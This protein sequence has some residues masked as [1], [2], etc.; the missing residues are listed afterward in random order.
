MAKTKVST[1]KFYIVDLVRYKPTTKYITIDPTRV[2]IQIDITTKGILSASEVPSAAFARLEKAARE[3][4]DTYEKVIGSEVERLEKKI[5][6]MVDSGDPQ[7]IAKAEKLA[8]G[9]NVSV[10]NALA[11]AEGAAMKA[12]DE[13]LKKEIQLDKNLKEAQLKLGFKIVVGAVRVTTNIATLVSTMGADVHA[14]YVIAKTCYEVGKEIYE[15]NKGEEKLRKELDAAIKTFIDLRGTTIMQAA[16]R[17]MVD[18]SGLSV[19]KPVEAIK[20]IMGR[21]QAG[22]AE[23]LKGR[24]AKGVLTEVMDFV[25]KGIKSQLADVEK[26]RV[27]YRNHTAKTI[28]KVDGLST[29]ADKLMKAMKAATNLKDGVKIGAKTMAMKRSV[30]AMAKKLEDREKFLEEMQDLMKGNGLSIDDRT[31]L[32]KIKDID[33]GTILSEG[34]EIFDAASEVKDLIEAFI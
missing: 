8:Q 30:T 2:D 22:G 1:H 6:T 14:Y 25:V 34:K 31:A 23:L 17:Q 24:D 12:V 3:A 15:Y 32:Q 4:L 7:E 19:S 33:L 27:A 9:V 11:S 18:T 5:Q 28:K 29:E 20:D 13:R 16:T 26:C 10:K 21:V